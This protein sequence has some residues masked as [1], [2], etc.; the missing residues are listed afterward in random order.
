M[1]RSKHRFTEAKPKFLDLETAQQV[2]ER[3]F[4]SDQEDQP[5]VPYSLRG[6]HVYVIGRTGYGKSTLL[7]EF[8]STDIR[9]GAGV[10][11]LDPKP[12]GQHPNLVN[13]VLQHIPKEREN[14]VIFF[15]A[16]DPIPIDVMSW[17]TELERQWLEGDIIK[18]FMQFVQQKEGD[19]WPNVLR[20]IVKTLLAIKSTN[21]LDIYDFCMD[22]DKRTA[23]VK[24]LDPDLHYPLITWWNKYP[25]MGFPRDTMLPIIVRM[26]SAILIPPISK[27]LG[28]AE[29]K[30]NI[31]DIIR[32]RKI[33]LVDLSS[34]GD[35][36]GQ[37]IGIL[38]VSRIQQAIFRGLKTPF[39]LFADEF[40][41][42]QTSA[43]DKILSEARSLGLRLTLAN[44]YL[45]QME[46]RIRKAIFGNVSTY[47]VLRIGSHDTAAF[48]DIVPPDAKPDFLARLSQFKALYAIAGQEAV[49]R[50]LPLPAAAPTVEELK[51][52]QSIRERMMQQYPPKPSN[53]APKRH[54]SD[55]DTP[56]EKEKGR[57]PIQNR[58]PH[59]GDPRHP[60]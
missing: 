52:A 10:C 9:N 39:H 29:K 21:Y 22:E 53:P 54:T 20:Y 17:G 24:K 6:Q 56:P 7:Y 1:Y 16:K 36:V 5:L 46:E 13:T 25:T 8:I 28:E 51:R 40:Q 31:E 44:Q 18:T 59:Q 50:P 42:F 23:F 41:S 45:D 3:F 2:V 55:N 26:T 35:E 48:K 34:A 47:F 14:D 12:S 43:F 27:M 37:F 19:R 33:L 32:N 11:V 58:K 4:P 60:R 30:L 49:V 57:P 38:L 15:D